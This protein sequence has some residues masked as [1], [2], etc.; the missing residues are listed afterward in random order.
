MI[1]ILLL[2]LICTTCAQALPILP[3]FPGAE[4]FG[5]RTDGG[6]GGIVCKVTNLN[7]SGSGSLRDCLEKAEPRIIIFDTGGIIRLESNL[8]IT[9]PHAA[10]FGQTAPGD[11]IMITGTPAIKQALVTIAT[12]D[13]L[14]Q[15]IRFRTA[16]SDADD[17]CHAAMAIVG[18][19]GKTSGKQTY[20]V[21]LD[22]CSFSSASGR[23][24]FSQHDGH[25]ITI[26]NSILGPTLY[27]STGTLPDP[28][29]RGA[30]F[31]SQGSHSI[32]LHH[33]LIVHSQT[34][35]PGFMTGK[36]VVD[37]V[38]NLVY[39]WAEAGTVISSELGNI[40]ANLI[41]NLYI[42]GADSDPSTPEINAH[43]AGRNYQ[44]FLEENL[45][46]RD[47]EQPEPLPVNFGLKDWPN[48]NWESSTRFTA[49]PITTFKSPTLRQKLLPG[50]GAT[51]PKRDAIDARAVQD[52]LQTS[53]NIPQ[54]C[55]MTPDKQ[56]A[57]TCQTGIEHW[58]VYA[59]GIPAPDRDDD[60]LPDS[61]EEQKG[62]DPD[63]PDATADKNVDGYTNIEEWIFSL[64]PTATP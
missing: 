33:N 9:Q 29:N 36:G 4:G 35:N 31:G 62:L 12:H 47:P 25:D 56:P 22:H 60:G 42:R 6:R 23:L 48:N 46:I 34:Q 8:T 3:V 58:Q 37:I 7:D 14:I 18:A 32:S 53:G 55:P 21:V 49:P 63:Q 16:P 15:H 43:E 44:L 40:Q 52:T 39:N 27:P 38:N 45:S 50:V 59:A 30:M 19:A 41:H 20:N 5:T 54:Q 11:G 28:D 2:Y 61:W 51:L 24:L 57:N 17:C 1:R 64:T 10:I 13:V 26:S